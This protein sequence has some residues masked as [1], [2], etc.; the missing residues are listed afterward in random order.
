MA[1][2]VIVIQCQR[3]HLCDHN[4]GIHAIYLAQAVQKE[5]ERK[6]SRKVRMSENGIY[7]NC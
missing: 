7:S 6:E 4:V 2:S 1:A 5:I 3:H